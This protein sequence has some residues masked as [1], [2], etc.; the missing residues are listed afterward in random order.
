MR[1]GAAYR[2]LGQ[3]ERAAADV[4]AALTIQPGDKELL[5]LKAKV[6]RSCAGVL[7][8]TDAG[9][10]SYLEALVCDAGAPV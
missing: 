5:A 3:Y 10:E 1:R 8:V 4:D 6:K 9:A 7:L 2:A